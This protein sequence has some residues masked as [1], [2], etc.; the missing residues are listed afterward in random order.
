MSD[1]DARRQNLG[2]LLELAG[3]YKG[4]SKKK[5]AEALGRDATKLFPETGNPKLDYL[6]RL[7]N[8][9]DWPIGEVAEAIWDAPSGDGVSEA[10]DFD[11]A[12]EAARDAHRRGDFSAMLAHSRA[13]ARLA[14][15]TEQRA[16]AALRESG[17]WDGMGRFTRQLEAVR[18][19]LQESP[20]SPDTGLLLRVNLANTYFTLG[21]LLEARAMARDLL[22]EFTEHP[23][24]T[25]PARAAEAFACY[26]HGSACRCLAAQQP[27][28]VKALAAAAKRSLQRSIALYLPLADEYNHEP[29]RG[30]ANTCSGAIIATEVELGERPARSAITELLEGLDSVVDTT[31]GLLGDRLESYGWWCI[32][33]CEIALRHLCGSELQRHVAVFTNKGYEIADRLD[34][35]AMRERLFTMEFLRRQR[36]NELAGLPVE[37]T[38]D[39][40]EVRV[41]VGAMGRFPAFKSTGWK[42]LQAA[43]V[44]GE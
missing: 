19:G 5:L 41:I 10:N 43:T 26:V 36:L 14:G 35:W 30:I 18:R 9:L 17:A 13:M 1:H 32:Y 11:T 23:P 25:R 44:V 39:Q 20:I 15:T 29:W 27:G 42:I 12:N 6:V 37:W 7:A 40:E 2:H 22:D 31:D 16:V 34:N 24:D 4:L 3:T 28:R 21:Q 33:G 38:I 8:L